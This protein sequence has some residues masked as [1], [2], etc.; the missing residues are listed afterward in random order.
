M[1]QSLVRQ[2]Q[3]LEVWFR[4]YTKHGEPFSVQSAEAFG[5]GIKH[6][7]DLA[8][9]EQQT[10]TEQQL[11]I[12]GVVFFPIRDMPLPANSDAPA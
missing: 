1:S 2:L 9:A 10:V 12:E 8:K 3:T 7:I 6:T 5:A 11:P 4:E